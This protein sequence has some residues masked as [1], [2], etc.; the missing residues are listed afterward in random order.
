MFAYIYF[1]NFQF[2]LAKSMEGEFE[3]TMAV[4]FPFKTCWWVTKPCCS[5][6]LIIRDDEDR[7]VFKVV[8]KRP[9]KSWNLHIY[10]VRTE[11]IA[12][13]KQTIT[14]GKSWF[15]VSIGGVGE[16]LLILLNL[17]DR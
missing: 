4:R 1:I 11:D 5:Q 12:M 10:D 9:T 17:W 6:N 14:C 3:Q 15:T 13:V 7:D 2:V 8:H 16:F